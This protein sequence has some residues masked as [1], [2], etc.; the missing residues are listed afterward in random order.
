MTKLQTI[1]REKEI[2]IREGAKKNLNPF[3]ADHELHGTGS[4]RHQARLFN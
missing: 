4:R 3:A 2:E 1:R